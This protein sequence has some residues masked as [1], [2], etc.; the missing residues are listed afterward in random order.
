MKRSFSLWAVPVVPTGLALVAATYGLVRLAFGL[1][2][3]DVQADLDL[4]T[5]TAG[6]VSSG[7]S[8]AYCVA[9][10]L[11]LAL[12][13]VRTRALLVAVGVSGAGG[14]LAMA[15]APDVS[16]FTVGALVGSASAGLLSP[17]MVSVLRR[18]PATAE[19]P[20]AQ[21]VVNAG[22]GP[23]L[24]AA[25]VLAL[26]LLPGWRTAWAW[27]AAVTAAAAVGVLA[28]ARPVGAGA[29]RAAIDL[30][31]PWWS[32][33]RGVLAASVLLG[34]SS[35]AVW[36]YG[37]ALLVEAGAGAHASAVAWLAVGLGGAAVALS[38][39]WMER[40]G[41]RVTWVVTVTV[42]T[43]STAV[44]AV[45]PGSSLVT[46]AAFA[47]F[48]W[49]FVAATGALIAWTSRIDP[50]RS[51]PGTAVLFVL[52]VAGQAV[53]SAA[54]GCA[55]APLGLRGAVAAAATVGVAAVLVGA[56][57]GTGLRARRGAAAATRGRPRA[58]RAPSRPC[59]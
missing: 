28:S 38:G 35:A 34:T 10:M 58:G 2:L 49:G 59:G 19:R 20:E 45:A 16:T 23:G 17:T 12:A 3:P 31:R 39:R 29:G 9:A 54:V 43:A 48:G 14:A 21:A 41:P 26:V 24:V 5:G 27:S 33:H 46:L 53:G 18:H 32:A 8:L 25:A 36:S 55:A 56:L 42:A 47:V 13:E 52:L 37:R 6:L 40:S 11:A 30:P 22:T 44:L 1:Y 51:A 4:G 50:V 7:A 57:A 15:W